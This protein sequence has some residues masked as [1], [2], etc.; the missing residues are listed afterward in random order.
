MFIQT[1]NSSYFC[2]F[3]FKTITKTKRHFLK[4]FLLSTD[5]TDDEVFTDY[6]EIFEPPPPLPGK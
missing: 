1:S 4:L 5:S 3:T 2:K 6:E